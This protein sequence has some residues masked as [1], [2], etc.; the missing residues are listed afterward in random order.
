MPRARLALT[1]GIV[2]LVASCLLPCLPFFDVAGMSM[3]Y[4]DPTP[5]MLAKQAA[6]VAAAERR[7]TV[8]A[9]IAGVLAVLGLAAL[10]YAW[11]HRRPRRTDGGI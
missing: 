11:K 2:L 1:A 4:Q 10:V 3:P 9:A 5:E 7:F 8:H 6:D